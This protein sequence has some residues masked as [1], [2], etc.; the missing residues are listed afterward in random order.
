MINL[1]K[2]VDK[3][4]CITQM[5]QNIQVSG[6]MVYRMDKVNIIIQITQFILEIS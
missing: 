3:E 5:D 1:I 6:K 4:L 2:I